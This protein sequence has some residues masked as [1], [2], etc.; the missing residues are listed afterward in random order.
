M[1]KTRTWTGGPKTDA[2]MRDVGDAEQ[3]KLGETKGRTMCCKCK[4]RL[5]WELVSLTGWDA[6]LV[7]TGRDIR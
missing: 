1:M 2:M 3:G 4:G 7:Q 6:E 5:S